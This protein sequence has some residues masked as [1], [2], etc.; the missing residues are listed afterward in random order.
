M[1]LPVAPT[2]H[3]GYEETHP[4]TWRK[5]TTC[6]DCS[7]HVERKRLQHNGGAHVN[8]NIARLKADNAGGYTQRELAKETFDAARAGGF[9]ITRAR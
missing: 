2:E 3:L 1:T 7:A 6:T 5:G 9:D 8:F 4:K